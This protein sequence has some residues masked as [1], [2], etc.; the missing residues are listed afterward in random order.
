MR[1]NEIMRIAASV[2]VVCSIFSVSKAYGNNAVAVAKSDINLSPISSSICKQV[3]A[4]NDN[5]ES[6]RQEIEQQ[7]KKE[8]E[9]KAREE[10]LRKRREHNAICENL[11]GVDQS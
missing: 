5:I 10:A 11:G 8:K 6:K 2:A 1:K 7:I 9:R 3:S 4:K